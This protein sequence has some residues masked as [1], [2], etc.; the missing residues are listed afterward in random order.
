MSDH[1][2]PVIRLLAELKRRK[3]FKA[4]ALYGAAVFGL[5]QVA[6]VV[7]PAIGL[8]EK[9]VT[10]LVIASLAGFPIALFVA[11]T[12]DFTAHGLRRTATAADASS[13]KVP[14]IAAYD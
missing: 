10:L 4:V 7:I 13:P 8:P 14:S 2:P 1:S 5:L 11:W 9:A 12:F 3:V 6:D